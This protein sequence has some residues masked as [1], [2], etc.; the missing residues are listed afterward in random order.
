[1]INDNMLYMAAQRLAGSTTIP[2]PSYLA[3]GSSTGTLTASDVIT[4]G[5]FD[6]NAL[7][8]ITPNLSTVTY[9][10]TR[11]A[12]EANNERLFLVSLVNSGT[13]Y[14]SSDIIS[15]FLMSS[16]IHTTSFD[17]NFE[18]VYTVSRG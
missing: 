1:M 13:A 11:S 17:L 4:S 5:E 12:A 6:R 8:S 7:T 16:M 18:L 3:F 14:G 2:L 9:S 15:N 10:G